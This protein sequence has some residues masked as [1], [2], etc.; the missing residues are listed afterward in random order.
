MEMEKPVC[1]RKNCQKYT[2][3]ASMGFFDAVVALCLIATAPATAENSTVGLS[4]LHDDSDCTNNK[5][6]GLFESKELC[7]VELEA[8]PDC[9]DLRQQMWSDAFSSSESSWGCRCCLHPTSHGANVNWDVYQVHNL[10]TSPTT[11]M[12]SMSGAPTITWSPSSAPSS[13]QP[14]HHP[15]SDPTASP[16]TISFSLESNETQCQGNKQLG[17]FANT[18]LCALALV[19]DSECHELMQLMWSDTYSNWA[20]SWGCRCCRQAAIYSNN[21]NWDLYRVTTSPTFSPSTLCPTTTSPSTDFPTSHNPSVHPTLAPSLNPSVAPTLGPSLQPSVAPSLQPSVGPMT[22]FPSSQPTYSPSTPAPTLAPTQNPTESP[23][24]KAIEVQYTSVFSTLDFNTVRNDTDFVLALR[25]AAAISAGVDVDR[26]EVSVSPGSVVRIM[27]SFTYI[28]LPHCMQVVVTV[29]IFDILMEYDLASNF[30]E[31]VNGIADSNNAHTIYNYD[32]NFNVSRYGTPKI[33]IVVTLG[34]GDIPTS[35]P[36][37]SPSASAAVEPG[38]STENANTIVIVVSTLSAVLGALA[39]GT[40]LLRRLRNRRKR[41]YS[42]M[43]FTLQ[44]RK[45]HR[46]EAKIHSKSTEGDLPASIDV[47]GEMQLVEDVSEWVQCMK[48]LLIRVMSVDEARQAIFKN[49]T[50]WKRRFFRFLSLQLGAIDDYQLPPDKSISSGSRDSTHIRRRETVKSLILRLGMS[51]IATIDSQVFVDADDDRLTQTRRLILDA[52]MFGTQDQEHDVI[53][54]WLFTL[55]SHLR[56]LFDSRKAIDTTSALSTS[57]L[58]VPQWNHI[59]YVLHLVLKMTLLPGRGGP[60]FVLSIQNLRF[61]A[62]DL[63]SAALSFLQSDRLKRLLISERKASRGRRERIDAHEMAFKALKQFMTIVHSLN[64]PKSPSGSQWTTPSMES[65]RMKTPVSVTHS[66]TPSLQPS[67]S[68]RTQSIS[69]LKNLPRYNS[70]TIGQIKTRRAQVNPSG[71]EAVSR[72]I[73][74][75]IPSDEKLSYSKFTQQQLEETK[76]MAIAE[77]CEALSQPTLDLHCNGAKVTAALV[78]E[79]VEFNLQRL[80]NASQMTSLQALAHAMLKAS[81]SDERAM[82]DQSGPSELGGELRLLCEAQIK[83]LASQIKPCNRLGGSRYSA[84]MCGV[85]VDIYVI[86]SRHLTSSLKSSLLHFQKASTCPYVLSF[87]GCGHTNEHEW[88]AVVEGGVRTL[89]TVAEGSPPMELKTCADLAAGLANAVELL[90]QLGITHGSVSPDSVVVTKKMEVKL[91]WPGKENNVISLK[92]ESSFQVRN[93]VDLTPP[94]LRDR[95]MDVSNADDVLRA[96]VYGVGATTR[97]LF[98]SSPSD[99]MDSKNQNSSEMKSLLSRVY[100]QCMYSTPTLR[101]RAAQVASWL[102]SLKTLIW[103]VEKEAQ[104]VERLKPK[105]EE[106]LEN[107]L[108]IDNLIGD[109]KNVYRAKLDSID[110]AVKSLGTKEIT[111]DTISEVKLL[112][113]F[114]KCP[115][116]VN[117]LGCG[118]SDRFGWYL[119]MEYVEHSLADLIQRSPA[120]PMHLRVQISIMTSEGLAFL[121]DNGVFHRDIKPSNILVTGDFKI[122][123]CDFGISLKFLNGIDSDA[124]NDMTV[125]GA[126]V[127]G[128]SNYMSPEQHARGVLLRKLNAEASQKIDVYALGVTYFELFALR[129]VTAYLPK[130][131]LRSS[132]YLQRIETS[133]PSAMA[134]DVDETVTED[135]PAP[136]FAVV[137]ACCAVSPSMRPFAPEIKSMLQCA[138]MA[139]NASGTLPSSIVVDP[140]NISQLLK[141]DKELPP[142]LSTPQPAAP[143]ALQLLDDEKT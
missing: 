108:M 97:Y 133:P 110:V 78:R 47:F 40:V 29:V 43:N 56:K 31:L 63:I 99:P 127:Y 113:D 9:H 128:T 28:Y 58:N 23:S 5:Q 24:E 126:G 84:L 26:V 105:E 73:E 57:S 131:S 30:T 10:T 132:F 77:L 106:E 120:L 124:K 67:T 44:A 21:S 53:I 60:I 121:H 49:G 66:R 69:S 129:K 4:L 8:D 104:Q 18:E 55:L 72:S 79:A 82:K 76:S 39:L 36:T 90:H 119:A 94:E 101:P 88:F 37:S 19:A 34:V 41:Y 102:N 93:L 45:D 6:L 118:F 20:P 68:R 70:S 35:S 54:L 136:L 134:F 89:R 85:R 74:T 1:R 86:G 139:L 98:E 95:N 107:F 123:L 83:A 52:C 12:P 91:A 16:H 140:I 143:T 80:A 87:F 117:T 32:T 138:H 115:F 109:S 125:R 33:T 92:P 142:E 46:S 114:A 38:P 14:T 71:C 25:E 48:R 65:L 103:K 62:L 61:A 50:R 112:Q 15:T 141:E 96:D 22:H 137:R 100:S 64:A 51:I 42:G 75:N 116:V 17:L 130:P 81:R 13:A 11:L 27:I 59:E 7:A 111:S 122:K 2:H 135:V 3:S